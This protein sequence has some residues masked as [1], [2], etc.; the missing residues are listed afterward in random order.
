MLDICLL[1][2]YTD[3]CASGDKSKCMGVKD[4]TLSNVQIGCLVLAMVVA[5]PPPVMQ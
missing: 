2:W 4:M 5:R 1:F 3:V